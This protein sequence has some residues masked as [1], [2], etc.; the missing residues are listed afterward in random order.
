ML[1][2]NER[3]ASDW[4]AQASCAGCADDASMHECVWCGSKMPTA[5]PV[6]VN[7]PKVLRYIEELVAE[8]R[9][10]LK[11]TDAALTT[12]KD[13]QML[14]QFTFLSMLQRAKA[15]HMSRATPVDASISTKF[16]RQALTEAAEYYDFLVQAKGCA[17]GRKWYDLKVGQTWFFDNLL[18]HDRMAQ[19]DEDPIFKG[20]AV[21]EKATG[22][23]ALTEKLAEIAMFSS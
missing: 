15:V 1:D 11:Q 23:D 10:V 19:Y 14:Y 9:D 6:H 13:R 18:A 3:N 12:L 4:T 20:S 7:M 8:C 2:R 21:W 17:L 5:C 22:I 16:S